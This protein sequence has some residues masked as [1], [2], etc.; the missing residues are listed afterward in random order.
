MSWRAG[1]A[2]EVNRLLAE[3]VASGEVVP[4]PLNVFQRERAADAFRFLAAGL[5]LPHEL[6]HA[7]ACMLQIRPAIACFVLA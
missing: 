2:W 6:M 5:H 4:L 1:Q 7:A 3:G